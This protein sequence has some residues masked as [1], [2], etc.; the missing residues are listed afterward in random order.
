MFFARS[1]AFFRLA[2]FVTA[3]AAAAPLATFAQSSSAFT[4]ANWSN[5]FGQPGVNSIISATAV[6]MKGNL[7]VGGSF[8]TAGGTAAAH[9]AKWNG[10]GWSAAGT[11][12]NGTVTALA[13][14]SSGNLF[15]VGSFG[16]AGTNVA[17]GIAKWDGETWSALSPATTVRVTC[18]TC[19][20]AGDVYAA[21]T[22]FG[23]WWTDR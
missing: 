8:T 20:S 15:A 13:S 9:I 12:F 22:F 17:N 4:D 2:R 11:G 1:R 14:D 18:L 10:A 21:G 6:D 3:M 23:G 16:R 7:Y 19:D 5:L